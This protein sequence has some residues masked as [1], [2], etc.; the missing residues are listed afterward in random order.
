MIRSPSLLLVTAL[1]AGCSAPDP[2]PQ[3]ETAPLPVRYATVS[4]ADLA[5]AAAVDT[6]CDAQETA[7]REHFATLEAYEGTPTLDDYY[8]SLDS[9]SATLSSVAAT[10]R[11]LSGVHPDAELR[12]AGEGCFQRLASI[13][14]DIGL[15]RPIYEAVSAIDLTGAEPDAR[16]SVEKMLRDFRLGGVDR[17]EATRERIR[18]LSEELVATGQEFDR[19]IREDVRTLELVSADDL[20]GLPDDFVAAHAPDEEGII[21]IT[22]RYPDLFPFMEYAERDD[23]RRAMSELNGQRGF[24]ANEAVLRSLLEKRHELA[25]LTGFPN[26]AALVTSDKMSGSPERVAAFIE[27]LKQYTGEVQDAEYEVLLARLREER[28]DA[29]RLE[30]WQ[31]SW[32]QSKVS[33]E[34]YGV[35][36][37]LIRQYF[38]YAQTRAGILGLVQ[39]LFE[40]RI[41]PW[42]TEVWHEEVEAYELYDGETLLGRFYLDM[43]PRD[44]KYQ[45]AAMFPFVNGI[46]GVQV[47]VAALVCN[48]PRGSEAMQFSQVETFLHEFGH[49]IHYQFAG[50]QRFDNVSGIAT[51]WDFVEAPSQMLEEWVWDYDTVSTFAKNAE[52][53]PLPQDLHAAMV[54]ERDFGLG[55]GTRGQLAFAKVSLSMYDR[56]PEEVDFDAL[57]DGIIAEMTRFE[58]LPDTHRWASFGHLNGYSAIYYT[59]QWSQAI[60]TDMFTRFEEAGMRDVDVAREYREKVLARGGSAPAETLVTDFLGREISFE[61]YARRLRGDD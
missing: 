44:G 9:L 58:S 36:S 38:D 19:N 37:L 6:I 47:P 12:A 29:E 35:D 27:E 55:M 45:H 31:R 32:I 11:S 14:T 57:Y 61:P 23:L 48:F 4:V 39:D 33:R 26:Y 43:H 13:G 49:L 21:R 54:A 1:A 28:P 2:S 42:E 59:Y 17:D 18:T 22:T 41:E 3:P 25:E 20:A 40:V 56:P 50:H 10:I 34:D 46:E 52:G 5:D 7:A 24:P 16:F 30:S 51:E 15:S 60:A 53:E 8:R